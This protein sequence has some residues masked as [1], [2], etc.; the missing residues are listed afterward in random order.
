[1]DNHSFYYAERETILSLWSPLVATMVTFGGNG[2]SKK[3]I[4]FG[5]KIYLRGAM[6]NK[7]KHGGFGH[8]PSLREGIVCYS[9]LYS[10][11]LLIY[12]SR[13]SLMCVF[14]CCVIQSYE[15]IR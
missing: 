6:P 12:L 9:L 3:S 13:L 4:G 1:M 5:P 14:M 7:L 11:D 10:Y 2:A 8:R 15:W